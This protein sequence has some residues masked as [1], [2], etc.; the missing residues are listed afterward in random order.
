MRSVRFKEYFGGSDGING[1]ASEFYDTDFFLIG[2]VENGKR[3]GFW[4]FEYDGRIPADDDRRLDPASPSSGRSS[5][6]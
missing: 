2:W 1:F 6:C 3:Y 4:P 5:V